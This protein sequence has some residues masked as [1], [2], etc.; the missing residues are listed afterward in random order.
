[1]WLER[2]VSEGL[3]H[4]SYFLCD[5]REAI[6]IDPRRDVA[7]YLEQARRLN[8]CI[9]AVLETHRHEDFILGSRELAER[10]GAPVWHA[11]AHLPYAYGQ[12]AEDGQTWSLGDFRLRA[13]STPGHTPGSMSYVLELASDQAWMVFTGDTLFADEVG[14]VD[15][16]GPELARSLA[17]QLYTSITTRLLPL[18]DGVLVW[19]AH[20]AGSMCGGAIADRLWTTIGLERALNPRLHLSREEFVE[21][22]ARVLPHP[23]YI[24][25]VEAWNLGL[26]PFWNDVASPRLLKPA[27]FAQLSETAQVVDTRAMLAFAAAHVPGALAIETGR[28]SQMAGWFLDPERPILLV[29]PGDPTS[30]ITALRRLG[31][32]QVVG[33]ME[34]V[35]EWV[36]AGYPVQKVGLVSAAELRQELASSP[37]MA[38]LDVRMPDEFAAGAIPNALNVPLI[39]IPQRLAELPRSGL[40]LYCGS[41]PR[42]MLAASLLQ[43]AGWS[44]VRILLGGFA[45]W[46]N[47]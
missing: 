42:S 24:R 40:T 23:P 19:P 28:L 8:V 27:E 14:R 39:S 17:D 37:S 1:M 44:E 34:G 35:D 15:F 6:V 32:D 29:C 4:H 38:L 10:T 12:A 20:G 33:Y 46:H 13:L 21:N 11:D 18:G 31:F 7:V 26:A 45:A 16:S 25:R 36:W 30:P 5:G 22:L 43:R 3:A 9:C 41:G 47:D 2:I